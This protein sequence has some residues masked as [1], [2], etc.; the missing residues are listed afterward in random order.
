MTI[1]G[2]KEG[3]INDIEEET[4]FKN[5]LDLKDKS[6]SKGNLIGEHLRSKN[7]NINY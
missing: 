2:R 4:I 1:L 3:K 5:I 6:I 7:L